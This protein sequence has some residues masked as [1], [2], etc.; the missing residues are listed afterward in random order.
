MSTN[1][2]TH[3]GARAR[4]G[5]KPIPDDQK[6]KQRNFYLT[7]DEYTQVRKF[8]DELIAKR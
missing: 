2:N 3:G 4:A 7:D 6:K 1:E 5:R 8:V